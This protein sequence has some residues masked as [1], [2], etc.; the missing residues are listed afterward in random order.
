MRRD[1]VPANYFNPR[2]YVK[3]NP[4]T[5]LLYT[6]Q[7]KRLIAIPEILVQSIHQTLLSEAGDAASMAFYTFGYSWGKSFYERIKKEIE[8]YYETSIAQMNAAEFFAV[9]QEVWGVHGL[10]KINVDFTAAKQGLL[11]VTIENSGISASQNDQ[12]ES[13]EF[14]V[15]AGFLSGWFSANTRQELNAIATDWEQNRTQYL[16]GAKLHIEQIKLNFVSKGMKTA[17]ILAKNQF[18]L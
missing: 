18:T 16:V 1:T 3:A 4:A 12:K 17:A 7:G 13:K 9:V 15:E 8:I 14:S 2:A 10:G 6:R 5:G 11:I